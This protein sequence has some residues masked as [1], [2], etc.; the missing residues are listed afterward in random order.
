MGATTP[1]VVAADYLVVR[2][3]TPLEC[4]VNKIYAGSEY[5]HRNSWQTSVLHGSSQKS[6]VEW[7]FGKGLGD[8]LSCDV[9]R[10]LSSSTIPGVSNT[11]TL[12]GVRAYLDKIADHA[13][14]IKRNSIIWVRLSST[15]QTDKAL[16]A[17]FIVP[18]FVKCKL[19]SAN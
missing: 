7:I 8:T 13:C 3:E 16:T 6:N 12:R 18:C 2:V 17:V 11:D 5:T 4:C 1:A 10:R 19:S 14:L 15:F 9:T